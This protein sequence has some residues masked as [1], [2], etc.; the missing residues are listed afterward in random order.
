MK[1]IIYIFAIMLLLMIVSI[2]SCG[3]KPALEDE[4]QSIGQEQAEDTSNILRIAIK[5]NPPKL[6]PIHATDNSSARVIYQMFETLVD[7]DTDGNLPPLL[8]ESW[9]ISDDKMTYIFNLRKG[10]HFHKT[11]EGGQPTENGGREV[12]ADDWIWTLN[13][14]I[15]PNTNSERA[16]YLN[17]VKGY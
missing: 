14:I 9:E 8:A 7:Y 2:T 11:I 12:K 13:N 1:K 3:Q 16:Y 4:Q 15:D 10:V 5:A 6:D 17:L